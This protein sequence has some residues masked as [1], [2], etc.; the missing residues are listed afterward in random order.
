[1]SQII[2]LDDPA[3]QRLSSYANLKAYRHESARSTFVTEGRLCVQRLLA[4]NHAVDSILVERGKEIEFLAEVAESTPIYSLPT[5]QIKQLVGYNFHRGVLACGPRPRMLE[6]SELSFQPGRSKMAIAVLGIVEHEN[7]GSIIRTATALG[8]EN[9]LV[10]PGTVDPFSRRVIRVSMATIFKQHL[11]RLE[12]PES[13]LRELQ[14]SNN[15]R[16]I[17]T[18]LS[19]GATE[20]DQFVLDERNSVLV[21]GNEANGVAPE[22]QREATDRV[23]IPMQLGTDSLNVAIA[24]AIIMH[25]L[26]R[27]QAKDL[28]A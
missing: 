16:T 14:R 2:Q 23:T 18:T 13:Q 25:D 9:I 5:E 24:A 17:V 19:P 11:F 26:V 8:I 22:V 1:V 3:D 20:L 4:S 12:H 6:I 15:L 10:G 27:R 28:R 21:F 7:L